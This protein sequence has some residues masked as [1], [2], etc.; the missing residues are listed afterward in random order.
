MTEPSAL[1]PDWISYC[2][3]IRQLIAGSVNRNIFTRWEM[4][5]LLDLQMT[6]IRKS[7][8]PEML[9]RYLHV[10]QLGLA[11]GSLVPLR[12]AAFYQEAMQLRKAQ[13]SSEPAFELP[14][15]S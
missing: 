7:S 3:L 4:D 5:L 15:A 13:E 8:R 9:R 14:R 6:P 1:T 2:Q 11:D 12:F 10:I